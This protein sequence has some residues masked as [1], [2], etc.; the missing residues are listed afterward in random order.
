MSIDEEKP[1]DKPDVSG[2]GRL[3][4]LNQAYIITIKTKNVIKQKILSHLNT[5]LRGSLTHVNF[6]ADNDGATYKISQYI[7]PISGD[8]DEGD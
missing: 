5:G 2:T 8:L 4:P 3:R 1:P 7:L 6:D